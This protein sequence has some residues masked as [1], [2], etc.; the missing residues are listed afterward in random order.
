MLL[1]LILVVA[2]VT[3]LTWLEEAPRWFWGLVGAALVLGGLVTIPYSQD[4]YARVAYFRGR[5]VRRKW[6]GHAGWSGTVAVDLGNGEALDLS[7]TSATVRP[8]R[9]LKVVLLQHGA[10]LSAGSRR[11]R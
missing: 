7:L 10:F 3:F 5:L 9:H 11:K 1:N 4:K 6:E 8:R 2:A